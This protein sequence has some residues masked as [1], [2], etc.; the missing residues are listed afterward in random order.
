ME[1]KRWRSC[2]CALWLALMLLIM[3]S[4]SVMAAEEPV[5][6]ID[7]GRVQGIVEDGVA[8]FKGIPYAEPPVGELRWRTWFLPG[9]R[10]F[11]SR[12]FP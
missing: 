7:T 6:I 5:I 9:R 4:E 8:S 1:Q 2:L 10:G 11:S 3:Q 12:R